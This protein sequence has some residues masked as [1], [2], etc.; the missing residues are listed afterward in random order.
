MRERAVAVQR[1]RIID[2]M[3]QVVCEEGFAG[4]TVTAVCTQAKVSRR[5]FYEVF[6]SREACFL[7]VIDQGYSQ[8]R[9]L[10]WQAF[11]RAESWRDGVRVAEEIERAE[12]TAREVL[13]DGHPAPRRPLSDEVQ[14]PRSLRNPRALRAGQCLRYL[15]EHPGASNRGVANAIGVVSHTQISTLLARLASMGLL[16][17]H[18]GRPGHPNAWSLTP[19]GLRVAHVLGDTQ[20]SALDACTSH[21]CK[22]QIKSL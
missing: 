19:Y 16:V 8:A 5:T 10:I 14:I 6:D 7:G 21:T 1:S 13:A 9:A 3:V 11:E 17:K 22:Q 2:A 15:V 20:G 18:P 12:R 4:A